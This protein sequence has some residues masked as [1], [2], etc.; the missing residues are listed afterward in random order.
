MPLD[1][2]FSVPASLDDRLAVQRGFFAPHT[3]LRQSMPGFDLQGHRGARGLQ[4]ENT[5]PSFERAIDVGVT[6]IETDVHLT[7]DG[8]PV[9]YHDPVVHEQLCRRL[10]GWTVPDPASRP[11]V[12]ALSSEQLR[13]YQADLNPNP[14]QFPGQHAR[15]SPLALLFAAQD[16]FSPYRIP[17]LAEFFAF[18]DAYAGDLGVQAG[19]TEEQRSRAR[20]VR[21]DLELKRVPFRS[22]FI[23]DDFEGDAPA[24]LEK[25]VVEITQQAGMVGRTQVRS[26]D[27]RSVRAVRRLEPRLAGGVLVAATAPVDPADLARQADAQLY[28]PDYRFLDRRQVRQVQE[29]H[30]RVVPWTVNE[31]DDWLRLLEWGVN[32]LTTDFPD[33]L[34]ALLRE[35]RMLF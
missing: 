20:Q 8:L 35:R 2:L 18:V 32:G 12:R 21:I 4:P 27:H 22:D 29:E 34:A 16:G 13:G 15:P 10:P 33:R 1:G 26:F 3:N 5:L 23:A 24:L 30:L 11:L 31:P 19:K 7:A 6:T 14:Q 9:I 17:L 25:R 28:C